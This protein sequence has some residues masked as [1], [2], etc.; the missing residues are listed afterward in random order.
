MLEGE[1]GAIYDNG[2]RLA[3]W[4]VAVTGAMWLYVVAMWL[5]LWGYVA[6]CCCAISNAVLYAMRYVQ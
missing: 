3:L 1:G 5:W 6:M 4:Y 2:L